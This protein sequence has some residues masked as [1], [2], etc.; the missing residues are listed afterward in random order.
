MD[1]RR[2]ER[3]AKPMIWAMFM[4]AALSTHGGNATK[5]GQVADAGIV[6]FEKRFPVEDGDD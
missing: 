4:N 6:E 2:Y 5:A 3:E 1:K